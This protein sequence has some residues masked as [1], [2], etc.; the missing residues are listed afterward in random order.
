ME[1]FNFYLKSMS[2]PSDADIQWVEV[3]DSGQQL[4][5][6]LTE[7]DRDLKEKL[8]MLNALKE[9]KGKR[10]EIAKLADECIESFNK[11]PQF[12][13]VLFIL[14]KYLKR[15]EHSCNDDSM[16][17]MKIPAKVRKELFVIGLEDSETV[18]VGWFIYGIC[19]EIAKQI[20]AFKKNSKILI[21]DKTAITD[22]KIELLNEGGNGK[23]CVV[24]TPTID[25]E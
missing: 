8:K 18:K 11:L 9:E 12:P 20:K 7:N 24:I 21:G 22:I 19:C 4:E 25:N 13:P 10:E 5:V 3:M 15:Y 17:P 23:E 16:P 1:K 6:T 14:S 2:D